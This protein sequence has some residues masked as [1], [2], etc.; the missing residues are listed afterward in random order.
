MQARVHTPYR[1]Q[2]ASPIG[3]RA[4]EVVAVGARDTEWPD[5]AWITTAD[6]NA[7]WGPADWLQ[8]RDDGRATALRDYSARELDADAGDALHL[9]Q[10]LGGW[11]WAQRGDGTRGWIPAR[12]LEIIDE[13]SA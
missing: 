13:T 4:G 10:E 5:F 3:W 8:P 6:G 9:H 7:G 1:T 11:W 2:Y 12:N